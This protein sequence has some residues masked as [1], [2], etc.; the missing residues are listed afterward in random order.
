MQERG[1]RGDTRERDKEKERVCVRAVRRTRVARPLSFRPPRT[2]GL[3]RTAPGPP[4]RIRRIKKKLFTHGKDVHTH[5]GLDYGKDVKT[6]YTGA[7]TGMSQA[8]EQTHT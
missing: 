2:R 8:R 6:S 3:S 7:G 5:S 1:K 4:A